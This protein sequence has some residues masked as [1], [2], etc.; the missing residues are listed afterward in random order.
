M[1]FLRL[2]N[3]ALSRG[4]HIL[5]YFVAQDHILVKVFI[6]VVGNFMS[7]TVTFPVYLESKKKKSK[8]NTQY[9]SIYLLS[10]LWRKSMR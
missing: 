3:E 7:V 10:V 9:N 1:I 2:G 8:K 6:S 4:R 5:K